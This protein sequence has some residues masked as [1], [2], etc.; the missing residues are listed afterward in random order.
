VNGFTKKPLEEKRNPLEKYPDHTTEH[1][2]T[3]PFGLSKKSQFSNGLVN[4]LMV[5]NESSNGTIRRT[6]KGNAVKPLIS[7]RFS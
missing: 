4:L 7:Q 5:K 3:S 6:K 1:S 2:G